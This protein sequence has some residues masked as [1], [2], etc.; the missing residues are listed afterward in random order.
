MYYPRLDRLPLVAVS[1]CTGTVSLPIRVPRLLQVLDPRT[2]ELLHSWSN[3]TPMEGLPAKG[4][5][6]KLEEIIKVHSLKP[7]RLRETPAPS[8]TDNE[9][10]AALAAAIAASLDEAGG[11]SSSA[12]KR[13]K[14]ASGD[15]IVFD[16]DDELNE[17]PPAASQDNRSG[18]AE[19]YSQEPEE[20]AAGTAGST[21]MRLCLPDH[22]VV[23]RRFLLADKVQKIHDFVRYKVKET[24][25]QEYELALSYPA[26]ILQN[27]EE[28][29][30]EA[31]LKGAQV[32]VNL[33]PPGE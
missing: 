6:A 30:L 20:P 14:G 21:K 26:K 16:D 8:T 18:W 17:P 11:D 5:R 28:T 32:M 33:V 4:V 10:A 25:T 29:V 12:P 22:S 23:A 31:N 2:G 3:I 24:H 7:K 9:E 1:P 19:K 27:P 15:P 13:A